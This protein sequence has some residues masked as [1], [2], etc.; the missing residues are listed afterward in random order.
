[1]CAKAPQRAS[2]AGAKSDDQ[3]DAE[4]APEAASAENGGPGAGS[5]QYAH[6]LTALHAFIDGSLDSSR[7][8]DE[9]RDLM[10]TSAYLLFTM[11]KL[12]KH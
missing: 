1:M 6:F 2:R 12:G 4:A 5:T 9:C 10:G 11:D 3:M 7:Y 8:E